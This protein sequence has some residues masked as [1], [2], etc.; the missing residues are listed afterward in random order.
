MGAKLRSYTDRARDTRK[1]IQLGFVDHQLRVVCDDEGII[2]HP[3]DRRFAFERVHTY[4]R[5]S[6]LVVIVASEGHT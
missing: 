1:Y 4:A 3:S 6:S 2:I 5:C